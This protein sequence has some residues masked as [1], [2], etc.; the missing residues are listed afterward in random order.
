MDDRTGDSIPAVGYLRMSSGEQA[1]SIEQ[2]KAEIERYAEK[3]GYR[4]IRWYFEPGRSGSKEQNQRVEFKR[5]LADS[6]QRDF[7]AVL[8][9]DVSRFG[10]LDNIRGAQA[11]DLLR[12]NGVHLATV[13]EGRLDWTTFEGRLM[14]AL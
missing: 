3:Q 6:D 7:R 1:G 2:Q 11:K 5:M 4:I 12:T 8:C 14:D 9:W 10:R 13:K